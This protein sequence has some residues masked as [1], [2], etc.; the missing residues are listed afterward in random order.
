[1]R[2][3]QPCPGASVVEHEKS[4]RRGVEDW[5]GCGILVPAQ[6][7]SVD[8]AEAC[9]LSVRFES[10]VGCGAHGDE[11]LESVEEFG[12]SHAAAGTMLQGESVCGAAVDAFV[13]VP[14][15]DEFPDPSWYRAHDSDRLQTIGANN[16]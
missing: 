9:E 7:P 4:P 1:M 8:D 16:T 10:V 2:L 6:L 15:V 5:F 13:V 12:S 11:V 3:G 14:L